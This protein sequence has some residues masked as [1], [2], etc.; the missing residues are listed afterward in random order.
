VSKLHGLDDR[1][2][3]PAHS[4]TLAA[5]N[6]T[7]V[8]LWLVTGAGHTGT[9]EAEPREFERRVLSFFRLAVLA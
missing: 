7:A 4:I 1:Q 5:S 9:Y 8:T 2:T 3:P 6:R